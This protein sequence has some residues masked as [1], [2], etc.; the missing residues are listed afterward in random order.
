MKRNT[1]LIGTGV[2][3][4][5][6]CVGLL[7]NHHIHLKSRQQKRT[8]VKTANFD[9]QEILVIT[10]FHKVKAYIKIRGIVAPYSCK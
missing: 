4:Y 8:H 6:F 3:V 10:K 9:E 1:I 7:I 2:L 5:F